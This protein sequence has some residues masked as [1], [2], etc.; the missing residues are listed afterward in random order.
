M[1]CSGNVFL[2]KIGLEQKGVE[3]CAFLT[4]NWPYLRN[5]E[6]YE[7]ATRRPRQLEQELL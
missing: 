2:K 3:K 7:M 1:Q 4:E 5:G 6:R